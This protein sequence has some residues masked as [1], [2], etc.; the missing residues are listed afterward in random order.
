[1]MYVSA[2]G[3]SEFR[4]GLRHKSSLIR[5]SC[6]FTGPL[7]PLH[8]DALNKKVRTVAAELI[9][10]LFN[11]ENPQASSHSFT[12]TGPSGRKMEGFG[13]TPIQDNN[14]ETLMDS[15]TKHLPSLDRILGYTASKE[16]MEY[17][18]STTSGGIATSNVQFVNYGDLSTATP[19][20][21]SANG[22]RASGGIADDS[23]Y[24]DNNIDNEESYDFSPENRLVNDITAE[25]GIRAIP[26]RESLITFTNRCKLLDVERIVILLNGKLSELSTEVQMKSLCVLEHLLKTT[27]LSIPN[28]ILQH[29][30]GLQELVSSETG[31]L[32]TKAKKILLLAESQVKRGQ[33]VATR[34]LLSDHVQTTCNTSASTSNHMN[35]L[36]GEQ[37]TN[38]RASE[39]DQMIGS[40]ENES[41][42]PYQVNTMCCTQALSSNDLNLHGDEMASMKPMPSTYE[43]PSPL[44]DNVIASSGTRHVPITCSMEGTTDMFHGL[45]LTPS[46]QPLPTPAASTESHLTAFADIDFA[47]AV[48]QGTVSKQQTV[49]KK[50]KSEIEM[51]FFDPLKH[52]CS[53][54]GLPPAITIQNHLSDMPPSTQ[55]ASTNLE[56]CSQANVPSQAFAS[57]FNLARPYRAGPPS[58][59]QNCQF[60]PTGLTR[61]QPNTIPGSTSLAGQTD[62]S[63][64]RAVGAMP[65]RMPVGQTPLTQSTLPLRLAGG[66]QQTEFDFISK[67]KR[68]E[69][70]SFVQDEIRAR[71]K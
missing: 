26:S 58:I 59:G 3:E 71:K 13:N 40:F 62:L 28:M 45:Q 22:Y 65:L 36:L 38:C 69:A 43:P 61:S 1:M 11:I 18:D 21:W 31:N 20:A 46:S 15:M 37:T 9:E 67:P 63:S 41:K 54:S 55:M 48:I 29:C 66:V 51:D 53:F 44:P 14:K 60:A 50:E 19:D 64:F 23:F 68:Q 33:G 47:P 12:L 30:P 34:E 16:G 4:S 35:P 32:H 25:G 57:D 2:H 5:D 52:A 49:D 56:P 17:R 27:L 7:D 70:F 8:G 42:S 39:C 6:S 10:L 24:E